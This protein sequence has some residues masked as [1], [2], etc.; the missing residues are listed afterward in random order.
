MPARVS[1]PVR[2]ASTKPSPPGVI[3]M[4][5]STSTLETYATTISDGRGSAPTAATTASRCEIVERDTT[6]AE[7]HHAPPVLPERARHRIALAGRACRPGRSDRLPLC[8]AHGCGSTRWPDRRRAA[9][10]RTPRAR[11][12]RRECRRRRW[13]RSTVPSTS[14]ARAPARPR[15]RPVS[16]TGTIT[17]VRELQQREHGHSQ[18]GGRRLDPR[19]RQHAHLQRHAAA[20]PRAG[21]N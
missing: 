18:H 4:R 3:G 8:G 20:A 15:A 17:T 9:A 12:P 19:V 7:Q 6:D 14:W 16:R 2:P 5:A 1:T 10:D 13:R 11:R 21:W